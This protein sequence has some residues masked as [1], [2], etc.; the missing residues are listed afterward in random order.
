MPSIQDILSKY[1]ESKDEK[2]REQ[3]SISE[4]HELVSKFSQ[5]INASRTRDGLKPLPNAF[6]N[7]KMADA[8]LK[9]N[10]DLYW[11]YSYCDETKNFDKTW[12]WSLKAR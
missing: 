4:R 1:K 8:Q 7:K 9:S 6:L 2:S 11:F 5:K 10:H 12:W 3:I